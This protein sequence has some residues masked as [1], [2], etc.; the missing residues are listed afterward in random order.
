M[1]IVIAIVIVIVIVNSNSN[2]KYQVI[3]IVIVRYYIVIVMAS[4]VQSNSKILYNNS[5]NIH[6][7]GGRTSLGRGFEHETDIYTYPPINVYGS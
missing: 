6:V 1:F 3:V 5:S 7:P 4:H 2:S